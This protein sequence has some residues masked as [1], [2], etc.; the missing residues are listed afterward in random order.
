MH[1]LRCTC[2]QRLVKIN[3][4]VG[5]LKGDKKARDVRGHC[6]DSFKFVCLVFFVSLHTAAPFYFSGQPIHCLKISG[7]K[8]NLRTI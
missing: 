7:N 4:D 1:R 6:I 5:R 3:W 2:I 8:N